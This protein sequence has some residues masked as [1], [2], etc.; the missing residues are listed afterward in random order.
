MCTVSVL[1]HLKKEDT[2]DSSSHTLDSITPK[3]RE[4]KAAANSQPKADASTT[5]AAATDDVHVEINPQAAIESEELAESAA[6]N[7]ETG[8]INWDCPC[9]GGMAHGPCGEEFRAAFSCFV[10]SEEEPKGIDCI[11]KFKCVIPRFTFVPWWGVT[12]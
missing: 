1:S 5:E 4:E 3:I 11:E 12:C 10:Y 9:L 8:E 7:P 2:T 6:F